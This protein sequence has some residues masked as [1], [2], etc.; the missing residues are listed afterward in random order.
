LEEGAE[1]FLLKPL[2]LSDL[3]K[4][5]PYFLKSLDNSSDEQESANSSTST[6][7]FD[8]DDDDLIDNNNISISKRKGIS[9]EPAERSRTKMKGLARQIKSSCILLISLTMIM[10]LIMLSS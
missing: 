3:Q 9:P 10:F 1:E 7:D 2:Q 6:T 8:D 5:Q 4:L